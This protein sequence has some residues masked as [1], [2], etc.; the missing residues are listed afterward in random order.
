MVLP[1]KISQSS[2][3]TRERIL[4]AA[5]SL[6]IER[7]FAATSLRA[8]AS[9]AE[10]NLAATH[11]HFGSKEGLLGATIHRRMHP[12]NQ[13]RLRALD[14][15]ER[16]RVPI[17]V[18]AVLAAFFKPFT[19][20]GMESSLP[21]IM[22]RIYGEPTS[23]TEPLLKEEFGTLAGRFRAALAQALPHVDETELRWR[24]HFL[25]GAM[26]Q[27]LS[28]GLPIGME[29]STDTPQEGFRRLQAFAAAGFIQA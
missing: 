1:A 6:F 8:I 7:G 26:V 17:T 28:F 9:L 22:G 27:L 14:A 29:E 19:E 16:S 12:I 23:I 25:I 18:D 3:T 11:Y 20:G 2:I 13:T 4:D 10:V 21:R 15:L 5:E 24:F